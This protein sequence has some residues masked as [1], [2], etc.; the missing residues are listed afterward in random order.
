MAKKLV[1]DIF[2]KKASVKETSDDRVRADMIRVPPRVLQASRPGSRKLFWALVVIVPLIIFAFVATSLGS[3]TV[4]L[5]PRQAEAAVDAVFSF[6]RSAAPRGVHFEIMKI[7]AETSQPVASNG[8]EYVQKKAKGTIVVYN[9]YDKNP[10]KL[11][12]GTRFQTPDGKIYKSDTAVVVPGMGVSD[13]KSVAG[14]VVVSV[15][16]AEAGVEYN[17]GLVDFTIPG[18]KSSPRYD[19]FYGRGKTEITGGFKGNVPIAKDTDIINARHA[20][21]TSLEESLLAKAAKELPLGYLFFK[22]ATFFKLE[23][24]PVQISV[25]TSSPG[26]VDVRAKGTLYAMI[27]DSVSLS[28]AIAGKNIEGYAGEEIRLSN[29]DQIMFTIPNK[30]TLNPEDLTV[31]S[32]KLTGTAMFTWR[33][34]EEAIKKELA[35]IS[36]ADYL[37]LFKHYPAVA[38]AKAVFRPPWLHTFP[39]NVSAITIEEDD[40]TK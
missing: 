36:S 15:T 34:D 27:I 26:A 2:V 7:E 22:D 37:V 33:I 21:E 28:K 40:L 38:R 25:G 31:F 20:I 11:V 13:G 16:A 9:T 17:I 23:F 18:F 8:V 4:T 1:Q 19:K 29:P 24:L 3:V 35:G 5:T 14:S 39:K 32:A 10:Q 30:K 12:A 6:E